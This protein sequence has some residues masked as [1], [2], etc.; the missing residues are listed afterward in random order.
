MKRQKMRV[1][2]IIEDSRMA[3]PQL[4]M[5]QVAT[6]LTGQVET[7]IASP[8]KDNRDFYEKVLTADLSYMSLRMLPPNRKLI[9]LLSY[10]WHFIPSVIDV[11]KKVRSSE[12]E[13]VHCS[14]GA[15]QVRAVLGGLLS[16][17][18]VVWHLND[19]HVPRPVYFVASLLFPLVDHFICASSRVVEYYGLS[20]YSNVSIIDAPVRFALPEINGLTQEIDQCKKFVTVCSISPVKGLDTLIDAFAEALSMQDKD[21]YLDIVGPVYSTQKAYFEYLERKIITLEIQKY[22]R[23]LGGSTNV[24]E[25]LLEYDCYICSSSSEASPTAV[26][27]AAVTGLSIISFDVGNVKEKLGGSKLVRIVESHNSSNL[28]CAIADFTVLTHSVAAK[29]DLQISTY[30]TT[31]LEDVSKKTYDVYKAL[32]ADDA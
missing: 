5:V 28:A 13:I 8:T 2:N 32:M 20:S 15:W 22:V 29:R 1:I 30:S 7:L 18:K 31:S 12:A 11:A 16:R 17:R 26:W 14:G 24:Q 27:E 6:K 9:S 19:S 23:F 3:G 21:I 10:F 4:R 25:L